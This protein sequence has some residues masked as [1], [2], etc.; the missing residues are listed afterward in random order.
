MEA[1]AAATA[2][3]VRRDEKLYPALGPECELLVF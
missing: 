2:L 1:V 3:E